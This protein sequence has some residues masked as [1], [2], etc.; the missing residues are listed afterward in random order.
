MNAENFKKFLEAN[1]KLHFDFNKIMDDSSV[2][3]LLNASKRPNDNTTTVISYAPG[4]N[5]DEQVKSGL[6]KVSKDSDSIS[7]LSSKGST[8]KL[9]VTRINYNEQQMK[10]IG[11]LLQSLM[12][13]LDDGNNHI[14]TGKPDAGSHGETLL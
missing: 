4:V 13:K 5:L 3:S 2:G 1:N 14:G 8:V 7:N 6:P 9:I 12:N 11:S 10:K